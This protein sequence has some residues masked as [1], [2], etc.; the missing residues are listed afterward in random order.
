MKIK[1]Q[2]SG[3]FCSYS[4][5]LV[6]RY[7]QAERCA[8][9]DFHPVNSPGCLQSTVDALSSSNRDW[10]KK[11]YHK[12]NPRYNGTRKTGEK[13]EAL[14][15]TLVRPCR[16]SSGLGVEAACEHV[17]HLLCFQSWGW[18]APLQSR[19]T[20]VAKRCLTLTDVGNY[21]LGRESTRNMAPLHQQR[22]P[23]PQTPPSS[24]QSCYM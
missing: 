7:F 23:F 6:V 24:L 20:A 19:C 14:Q 4:V 12:R 18:E 22:V 13:W 5:F 21:C 17:V 1:E 2:V 15:M 8:L 11:L 9:K 3:M 16:K 10:Y